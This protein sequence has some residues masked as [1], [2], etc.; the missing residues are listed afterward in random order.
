MVKSLIKVV[1]AVCSGAGTAGAIDITPA[2]APSMPPATDG[3]TGGMQ[4]FI[5]K[6][7]ESDLFNI[8]V[9]A[10]A[11]VGDVLAKAEL[12]FPLQRPTY[13][14]VLT[15]GGGNLSDLSV[16]LADVGVCAE[17]TLDLETE[18]AE[19]NTA[20]VEQRAVSYLQEDTFWDSCCGQTLIA[21]GVGAAAVAGTVAAVA[22]TAAAASVNPFLGLFVGYSIIRVVFCGEP[23]DIDGIDDYGH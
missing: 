4:L 13:R 7:G 9:P 20:L 11:T 3:A 21:V 12:H 5:R 19:P 2:P 14:H 15:F 22:A 18:A 8:E 10:G 1:A 16:Q 17:A 23:D 6:G